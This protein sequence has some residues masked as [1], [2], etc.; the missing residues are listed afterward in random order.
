MVDCCVL[1]FNKRSIDTCFAIHD[2]KCAFVKASVRGFKGSYICIVDIH[3]LTPPSSLFGGD[4]TDIRNT[5]RK[6]SGF[7]R[8]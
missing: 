4:T 7:I 8:G 5:N 1:A 2:Y 3:L 6:T